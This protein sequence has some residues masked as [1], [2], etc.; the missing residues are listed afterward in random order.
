MAGLGFELAA[1]FSDTTFP[2]DTMNLRYVRSERVE[3]GSKETTP[4]PRTFNQVPYL[5]AQEIKK[6]R[7]KIQKKA[8]KDRAKAGAE[9]SAT[10]SK[11]VGKSLKKKGKVKN[12]DGR[13]KKGKKNKNK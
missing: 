5:L 8:K 1:R 3:G 12:D 2:V 9:L 11:S 4:G 13:K 6:E 10:R 7:K